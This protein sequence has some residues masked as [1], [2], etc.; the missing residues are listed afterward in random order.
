MKPMSST[1]PMVDAKAIGT[2][3]VA[4]VDAR[5]ILRRTENNPWDRIEQIRS[6]LY[7]LIEESCR[8]LG[9]EA[10][11]LESDPYVHPAWV[12]VESW[13]PARDGALT[14]RAAM[15]VTIVAV[16][17]HRYEA[18]Y[19]V[20]WRKLGRSGFVDHLFA[21][22]GRQVTQMLNFLWTEPSIPIVGDPVE[23]ILDLVQLRIKWWQSWKPK[24]K[25]VALRTDLAQIG[26]GWLILA[27]TLLMGV[28][29]VRFAVKAGEESL[30]WAVP[31]YMA[32]AALVSPAPS[33]T[34]PAFA[35]ADTTA[36][37]SPVWAEPLLFARSPE[38]GLLDR[39]DRTQT[40]APFESVDH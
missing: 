29:F 31:T 27:G 36:A 40:R 34:P 1:S 35:L 37:A 22:G 14:M 6:R 25:P 15:T 20:D 19:R 38:N 11:V 12:T 3:P 32:V 33:D 28:G 8:K 30:A 16:P 23:P 21:F 5:P 13:K 18:V 7:H 9:F 39:S 2:S 4:V 17:Y 24:N 10:L 26:A